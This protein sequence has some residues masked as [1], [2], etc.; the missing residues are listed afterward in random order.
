[1]ESKALELPFELRQKITEFLTSLPII[2]DSSS[3]QAFIYSAGLDS[4]LQSQL[5]FGLPTGQFVQLLLNTLTSYSTLKDGRNALE[6]ILEAAKKYVGQE[7]QAYC[8]SL[9]QELRE[10]RPNTSAQRETRDDAEVPPKHQVHFHG[11]VQGVVIGDNANVNMSFG[12]KP[13]ES[14][15]NE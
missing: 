15:S 11:N 3:Q 1:M 13:K 7:R 4:N 10:V 2:H 14:K 6:A 8:D 9:I 12:E 5:N